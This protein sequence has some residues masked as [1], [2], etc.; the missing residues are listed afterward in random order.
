MFRILVKVATT[1][2]GSGGGALYVRS[3][4]AD[5]TAALIVD[6]TTFSS[7]E[8]GFGGGSLF[9]DTV[10]SLEISRT[11]FDSS[12]TIVGPGEP[13]TIFVHTSTICHLVDAVKPIY[14]YIRITMYSIGGEIGCY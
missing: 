5:T 11:T 10:S 8:A 6:G 7:D 3:S 9:V 4:N 1:I 14:A 2:H 13:L 12:S